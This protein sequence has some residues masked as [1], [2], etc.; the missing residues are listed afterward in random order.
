MNTSG[1]NPIEYNVLVK[2]DEV[3]E[4]KGGIYLPTEVMDKEKFAQTRGVIVAASPMAFSFDDWPPGEAK[5]KAGDKV[6]FARHTG[7]FVEGLDG[8]E[9]RVVKDKD[10]VAIIDGAAG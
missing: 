10:I 5:P 2:Q 3:G 7:T 9:Y 8:V 1:I 6:A 4:K